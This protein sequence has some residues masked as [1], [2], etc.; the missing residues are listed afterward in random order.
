[1]ITS[2]DMR[3]GSSLKE[4]KNWII[5]VHISR[6]G[7]RLGSGNNFLFGRSDIHRY[8]STLFARRNMST[9]RGNMRLFAYDNWLRYIAMYLLRGYANIII[10][11]RKSFKYVTPTY[12]AGRK[13]FIENVSLEKRRENDILFALECIAYLIEERITYFGWFYVDARSYKDWCFI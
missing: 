7:T 1:M 4:V 10:L 9:C 6:H 3:H 8:K 12:R 13:Y 2:L 11:K 5:R